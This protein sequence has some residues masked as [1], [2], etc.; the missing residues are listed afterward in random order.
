MQ[1]FKSRQAKF[2]RNK[3][4]K[5]FAKLPHGELRAMERIGCTA[6]EYQTLIHMCKDRAS[7]VKLTSSKAHIVEELEVEA[8]GC[9][10]PVVFN[11]T[12]NRIIT[13]K[14]VNRIGKPRGRR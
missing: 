14:P 12:T 7:N 2:K 9:I 5:N 1:D 10:I 11:R 4:L 8:F 3:D 13:V 6:E